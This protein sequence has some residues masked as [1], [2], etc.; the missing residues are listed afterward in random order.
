MTR[1]GA[2]V[3]LVSGAG[4]GGGVPGLEEKRERLARILLGLGRTLVAYSGGVD[5][6]VL[7]WEAHRVLGG[8]ARG[9]IADS[10]SLARAE[11]ESALAL[12]NRAGI[13][14]SVVPTHELERAAYRENGPDR[15]YHCKMELF[16]T[17]GRLA[18]HEG[19]DAVAYGAV[20][21]DL[22]DVRPGMS[23]ARKRRVRAPLLEAGW[24]KVEVRALARRLG[25][26]TWD[27]PQAA[28]LA[29]RIPHGTEVTPERL[30]QVERAEDGLRA[31]LGLRV[32]R[33]RHEGEGAR[34]EVARE[35]IARVSE[36]RTFAR[37]CLFLST[38]GFHEV[39]VDP[40]GYLRADP[41]PDPEQEAI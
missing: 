12:A 39:T 38:L 7:L 4:P 36:A 40:R 23:A 1:S 27:K 3:S 32:L 35:D 2:S 9:V 17:L 28:C 10:P 5:S 30:L 16:E 41:L 11:L 24:S 34:I 15:C 37:I 33:V 29:S 6:T 21:D 25:L 20:T 22:G 13:P 19:W 14:V 8:R 31:A 26:P 18:T